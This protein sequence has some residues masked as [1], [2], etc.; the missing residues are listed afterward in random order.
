MK[1]RIHREK[2]MLRKIVLETLFVLALITFAGS[3]FLFSISTVGAQT[4]AVRTKGEIQPPRPSRIDDLL[5]ALQLTQQQATTVQNAI[6]TERTAMRA[7]DDAL[8]PQREAIHDATRKKLAA[9]LSPEQMQRFEAWRTANRPPRP[10][11]VRDRQLET[12]VNNR[13]NQTQ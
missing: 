12:P 2:K 7:L 5:A 9:A 4:A 3:L 10:D 11:G 13:R 1:L 8:R 6:D